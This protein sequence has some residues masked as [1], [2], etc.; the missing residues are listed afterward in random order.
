MPLVMETCAYINVLDFGRVIAQGTPDRDPG[1]PVGAARVPRRGEGRLVTVDDESARRRRSRCSSCRR[2][3]PGTARIDVLHGVEL[4]LDA[5]RGLRAARA[6]TAPASRRRSAVACGQIVPHSGSLYLCGRDVTGASADA[7]A[8]AG[9]CL[10]PEGRG[11][12]PNLTVAENLRMASFTGVSYRD[13]LDRAFTQFP[14]LGERR[15]QTAGTLSGGEQQMLAMARALATDPAVLADR[16]ALDGV[17]RPSSSRSCTSTSAASPASGLSILIVEQFAHEIL[18]VADRAGIMLHGRIVH[19]GAPS[20]I[21]EE[22]ADAYLGDRTPPPARGRAPRPHRGEPNERR[23]TTAAEPEP[24][25]SSPRLAAVPGR[26]R[27]SSRSPAAARTPSASARSGGSGSRSSASSSSFISWWSASNAADARD[28]HR[29]AIFALIGVAISVVGIVIWLR[30]SMTRYLRYWIIRLVYEQ[31]EQTEQTRQ[32]APRQVV[33]HRLSEI[34]TSIGGAATSV[35]R[36][37]VTWICSVHL[38]AGAINNPF[39]R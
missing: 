32:G 30:N 15:K 34:G 8:R 38:P 9:V 20:F 3:A 17:W 1:R 22:L 26:G 36:P 10:I 19:S 5:R 28:I 33:R 35:N 6:R 21:A 13:V 7:L 39:T 27:A 31:R 14:R 12:F 16:R 25:M 37:R 18:G 11:I 2:C 29:V 23:A 24:T 4:A